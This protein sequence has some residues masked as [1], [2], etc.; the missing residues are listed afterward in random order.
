[1]N[2]FKGEDAYDK[3][4]DFLKK[5][6]GDRSGPKNGCDRKLNVRTPTN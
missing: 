4:W 3:A 1:M 6:V 2:V 5:Q